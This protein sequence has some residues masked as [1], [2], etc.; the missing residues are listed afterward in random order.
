MAQLLKRLDKLGATVCWRLNGRLC[1]D[2]LWDLGQQRITAGAAQPAA[3][4]QPSA[5]QRPAAPSRP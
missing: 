1:L 3:A 2:Q 4:I 5:A